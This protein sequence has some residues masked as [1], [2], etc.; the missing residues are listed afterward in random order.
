MAKLDVGSHQWVDSLANCNFQLY[1]QARKTNIDVD[2]LSRVPWPGC[3][4]DNSGTH[5]K[6]TA[7]AVQA[8]QKA[9]LKGLT[10]PTEAYS[11]NLHI[12]DAVQDS[13]QVICMIL[14]DWHQA[15][16]ADPI[17]SLVISRLQD[18]TL[19][20]HSLNRRTHLSLASSCENRITSY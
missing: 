19:G 18:G 9:A 10:S 16:Q 17:L 15:Q 8:V 2:A 5:L 7:A 3:M 20:Q 11:C 13:Q 6:V 4:P 12:L 14:E 1:Y